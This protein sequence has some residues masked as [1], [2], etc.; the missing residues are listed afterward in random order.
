[1][2]TVGISFG[3][4]TSG[5]GF[6]VASTV[7]SIMAVERT[8]E[9]A[10]AT[11]TTTL[12]GQD[13]VL[14][15]LGINTSALSA[16]MAALTSFDGVFS[17]KTGA[18][19]D[20]TYVVLTNVTNSADIASHTISVQALAQ[21]SRQ[22]SDV[23]PASTTLSGTLKLTVGS[24]TEHDIKI[25]ASSTLA[26][27]ASQVNAAAVGVTASLITDS[28]GS[29]LVLTSGTSGAA[30]EIT[31]DSSGLTDSSGNSLPLTEVQAGTDAAYTLDGAS[32]TSSSNTVS[33]ALTGVTFQLVAANGGRGT[34]STPTTLQVAADTSSVSTALS[35]FVSAYNSLATNL[36]AQEGKDS[37]GNAEPLFGNPIVQQLQSSLS[38]ALSFVKG[39]YST[40]TGATQP[41]SLATLGIATGTDG[42]LTL[43]SSTLSSVLTSRLSDMTTFFQETKNF[44]QNFSKTLL[45][46]SN[47]GNGALALAVSNNT[48]EERTLADNKTNLETRLSVYQTN[49]TQELTTANEILQ[50]IPTQLKGITALFDAITGKTS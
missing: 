19:S 35:T 5:T 3:S 44:G 46:L 39:T 34:T 26:Q 20:S 48:A 27:V 23:V 32:L 31:A 2:S 10:W 13:A 9:T 4:A 47:T 30:G 6:D 11:R 15:T 18:T 41:M 17:Q 50:S 38:S 33:T 12:Q 43:D 49:L 8:P 42:T 21:T 16:A 40:T 37:S 22:R 14:S 36:N 1:M 7:A 24:G 29:R 28:N 25:A 45:N